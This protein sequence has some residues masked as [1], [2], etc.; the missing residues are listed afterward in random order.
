MPISDELYNAAPYTQ[1]SKRLKKIKTEKE[2]I[3]MR[4]FSIYL[5]FFNIKR[6]F[7]FEI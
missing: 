4:Y 7:N 6:N 2:E 5:V 1:Q 3:I